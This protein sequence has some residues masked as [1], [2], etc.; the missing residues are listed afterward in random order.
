M[1]SSPPPTACSRIRRLSGWPPAAPKE[2]IATDTLP[3][4]EDKRFENLTVL[5]IAPL[6]AQTIQE[7]FE[8]GSV[9]SLFNGSASDSAGAPHQYEGGATG[10]QQPDSCRHTDTDVA[11]TAATRSRISGGPGAAGLDRRERRTRVGD[12]PRCRPSCCRTATPPHSPALVVT[13]PP[14][15]PSTMVC[16]C[17]LVRVI[18]RHR[19][20]RR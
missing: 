11:P 9:T 7:A 8:N 3:I 17:P 19:Q 5:S 4:P 12:E 18:R 1:S 15:Q 16:V 20:V 13:P 10:E 14:G 2:V 6:L